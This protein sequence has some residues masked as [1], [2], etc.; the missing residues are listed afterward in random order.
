MWTKLF[1][2]D[3][4]INVQTKVLPSKGNLVYEYNPFRNYRLSSN[5]YEY[6]GG[7]YSIGDL[8]ETFGISIKCKARRLKQGSYYI[9]EIVPENGT[10][11]K[12]IHTE[13]NIPLYEQTYNISEWIR[14]I[15]KKGK[16]IDRQNFEKALDEAKLVDAWTGV[17]ETSSPVLREK[18]ELVDFITDE[19]KIDL[20]HP[21]HIIPQ[22]SYDGSVNLIINDG[23]NIPRL[24]NSRFSATGKNTYEIIDRK[25][26]NDT[27]IYDQGEQ[28][29]S[30]TSLYK[31]V[32][33]IPKIEFKGVF[34]GGNLKVGNY[35]FYFKLS[36]Q[37]GNETDFIGES[38]LVSVFI[39]M[40][41]PQSIHTGQRDENSFKQIQFLFENLDP[42]YNYMI[43]YYSRSTAEGQNNSVTEYIKIDQ[44]FLLYNSDRCFINI[45]GYENT[46]PVTLQD[47]N[48]TYNVVDAAQ[49][50]AVCQNML[51]M[52][53]VHNP[54][55]PYN[56]LSD[57]SLR[58]LPYLKEE[59]YDI[60][61][62]QNYSINT[63]EQGYI[64]PLFIYNKTG[65]WGEEI[66]RLGIVYILPNGTLSPVFNIRGAHKITTYNNNGY[67][68]IDVFNEDG[69]RQYIDFNEQTN[70]I[71][72]SQG[73]FDLENTKGVISLNP[74][75]DTNTI[76]SLD[77]R[78]DNTT[79][80]ELKKYVKGYFFVRQ[81]RIPTI[82][83]QAVTIGIDNE[84]RTPTIP[85]AG[86]FIEEYQDLLKDTHV[87]TDDLNDVNYI[88]E[89]FLSRYK[90]KISEKET[91][92]WKKAL[93]ITAIA[94]AAVAAVA[95]CV[96]APYLL[97]GAYLASTA[98]VTG[99][100]TTATVGTILSAAATVGVGAVLTSSAVATTAIIGGAAIVGSGL[101]AAGDA[102]ATK[103]NQKK[104]KVTLNGR[105]SVIPKGYELKETD[106]SR[107][108][109]S[110]FEKRFIIKDSSK[111]SIQAMICPDY[112]INQSYFNQIFTGNKHLIKTTVSQS[113]NKSETLSSCYFNNDLRHFYTPEYNDYKIQDQI[114]C[115][116][117]TVPEEVKAIGI[118]NLIFRSKA[119][120]AE[121]AWRYEFIGQEYKDETMYTTGDKKKKNDE[122]NEKVSLKKINS[123]II[124]GIYCPYLAFTNPNNI[125]GPAQTVNIYIPEYSTNKIA[126]YFQIRMQDNSQYYAIGDR[127]DIQSIEKKSNLLNITNTTEEYSF[128]MY[129]GDCYIC[130]FTQRIIRNFN[131]PSAPYNDVIVDPDSW[132]EHYDPNNSES[133]ADINLGDVNA[134]PLGMWLTFRIRSSN[135]LNVRTLDGSNIDEAAMSGHPRGYYPY[136]PM[137]VEGSYKIPESQVYNKGFIKSVSDRYNLHISDVPH[138]K[139]WFGTRIIYSDIH[140]NDAFKN[141]FRVFQKNNY[142]DYT[143]E[144]G[145]ITKLISLGDSLL[146]IFEHGIARIP[147]NE[148]AVAGQGVG[149]SV[150]IN[151]SNV[152]PENP[153]VITDM[154][155]SQWAESVLKVP[156]KNGTSIQ[157]IYG[158]DTV[159]KK[160]WR[161]DGQKFECISDN[162]VQEFLNNNITLGERELTPK[163]GIRN[164]KTVYN[165]FKQ[166]V[167]FTFYDN[168]YGFEEKVWN[169]C[170][171]EIMN[172]FVTFY[173]WVPSYMENINNI[174]FS[175]NRDTSKWIA[176]L[177]T[178]HSDS[179]IADGITL[180]NNII[181]NQSINGKIVDNFNFEYTYI[182]K[183]GNEVS[184]IYNV[185]DDSKTNLVGV[186][187]LKNRMLPNSKLF[188]Q[189]KFDIER[190]NYKNYELFKIEPINIIQND[191]I[192]K[193]GL[194]LPDDAKYAG[195]L[196]K[197]YGLKLNCEPK[198]LFSEL[199]Y[200][201]VNNHSYSDYEY[202]DKN[203]LQKRN[204]V[205]Y[206]NNQAIGLE[207]D[208]LFKPIFKDIT[209]NRK[210]LNRKEQ[211]NPDKIV[212]LINIKATIQLIDTNATS[213]SDDYYN[214]KS[215][216]ESGTSLIN[217]GYYESVVAVI[218]KWNMQF[219]NTDFWKHGQAG[220]IDIA[221]DIYPTYWYGKQ[222]PF[223]FECV[224]VND[225][226]VH[227]IFNNIE[228][229]ANKAKPESFHY[230]IIG[231]TY[232]FAKDKPNMYYRQEAM[233]A[234]WQYNGAD[235]CYNRNFLKIQPKQ[236]RKSAD[237]P[238]KYYTRQDTI[239]EIED[240]Y[241]SIS[242]PEGSE[243]DYKHLSGAEIVYYKN[244]Q[245]YRIWQH[246]PAVNLDDL[247]Q[248]DARS[249]ISANCQYLENKWLINI[250]P[251]IVC[252]KNEYDENNNSTWLNE[253]LPNLPV[254]NSP[255]PDVAYEQIKNKNGIV[256]LPEI[257][258]EKG[259]GEHG[260]DT[261][262]WLGNY[263][264]NRKEVDIRDRYIKIRIR[265]S[266][267]ELAVI[268]FL[269]TIYRVSYG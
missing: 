91:E 135:N 30:D 235:V 131:D 208:A 172:T 107:K 265:Y 211:L 10:F 180:S 232:D 36:D 216:L 140:I 206:E 66:Y 6:K 203:Q 238:H 27:N 93:K 74:T 173:S 55:I 83:T 35:H 81:K 104:N 179:S 78:V 260:I 24:I 71:I 167:L 178:S 221:D 236:Q 128:N 43:V 79:I 219:L 194:I 130:Q 37:D 251:I 159:A 189:I 165:A 264:E 215:G 65:Y 108:L 225:P 191:I 41:T 171:N 154:Y 134:I 262:N 109:T 205:I 118:D 261:D 243:Y 145:S 163:I 217:A 207:N 114:E 90:F 190:D 59:N 252:Y 175:F 184:K 187:Q 76:Y 70:Y 269:N 60:V 246:S 226:S 64:D 45:T 18:G 240:Y 142:R 177:G 106:E 73:Q 88:S 16:N 105:N 13:N 17:N 33:K 82:L 100:A 230:E 84:S 7:I 132:K 198:D 258:I 202:D 57:L 141:G 11:E 26:N 63:Y 80:Q 158:V 3:I 72:D 4:T 95:A 234:I 47:I 168:T 201:N 69:K 126:T 223:E 213:M 183:E 111:N 23:I 146:V 34:S 9:F 220:I 186:F 229:I 50:S 20:E 144:F 233:K 117:I 120:E 77:I 40:S 28:F 137:S 143:R 8:Y 133:Y 149:G 19:L 102:I 197:I 5:M 255:I 32:S 51:F 115:K 46:I 237:F 56:E 101:Y 22:Y 85:T 39:G 68:Q 250:N 222:H 58:F 248:E 113:I 123:D 256:E 112:S 212:R 257:L 31:R 21:L 193:E 25:G 98:V 266:G 196:V 182:N 147:V 231:E 241:M 54:D 170:W 181:N 169:L 188:Y 110:E 156:G 192:T 96:F 263:S 121:E 103:R 1:K 92:G 245:E 89:G 129:R 185:A 138:Y 253:T 52:A 29:D 228:L 151:T 157:W 214:L 119:G 150:Y 247:S 14:D 38:G 267:E 161:T 2:N 166:D 164:V 209:G 136:Y 125:I 244:R 94:V 155:G 42:A 48:L 259:Y 67:S 227:K 200:R 249:I 12:L 160:I 127:I 122:K 87:E 139:N 218:P 199:Y 53:N 86:G 204:Y 174:P 49:T 124:R 62:D 99:V 242:L 148:R 210:M 162:R 44:K 195:K 224:V 268:N 153:L 15:Y 75:L 176:K 97:A 61:M 239:N 254:L 116:I 152:L